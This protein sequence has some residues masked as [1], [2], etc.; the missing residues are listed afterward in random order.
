MVVFIVG[1]GPGDPGLITLKAKELIEKAEI[2]IYDKLINKQ[3]LDWARPGCKFIYVG[4]REGAAP[5]QEIQGDINSLIAKYGPDNFVVRLKG[6]DPFIFGR[7]GE[8]A[9]ECIKHGIPFEVVPGISSAF[10]VPAYAGVPVSHRDFNSTFAVLTGHESDKTE[11]AIDW[12]HLPENI[13]ILMGVSKIRDTAQKLLNNGRAPSTPVAAI[14]NGTTPKQ[15][16]QLTTLDKLAEE[17][18]SLSPPVIFVVGPVAQLHDELAWFEKKLELAHGKT[19]VLT[20]AK[21][22]E[23]ESQELIDTYGFNVKLMPLIEIVSAEFTIPE[24]D[25]YD[26]LVLTSL[27]GVKRVAASNEVDLKDFKGKVFAIGPKTKEYLLDGLSIDASMGE[28]YNSEGLAEHII[29]NLNAG[30]KILTLRS[31]AASD[32]LK[33]MLS[34]KFHVDEVPIYDIKRLPADPE[35]VMAADSV[36]V[37]SASCAKSMAELDA[38]VLA[39]KTIVSI[40]PET[41]KYLPFSHISASSHTIQ[42]MIDVYLNY[43]WTGYP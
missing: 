23:A 29:K 35:L 38:D 27:E 17:G 4:K 33:N 11:S 6:G 5:S 41:S 34:Q 31:S 43:L 36:F 37:V 19:I 15:K 18:V 9:Q 1:A 22:H 24:L 2:I 30:S 25:A 42:G 12:V 39:G 16:T 13:V 8:E 20:R 26:A 21:G 7:G 14:H 28:N 3:V 40:G 10:A 32:T